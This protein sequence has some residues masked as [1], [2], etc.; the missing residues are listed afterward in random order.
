M[1]ILG[2]VGV[3]ALSVACAV[4]GVR[5]L[6]VAARTRELPELSMGIAFVASGALGFPLLVSSQIVGMKTPGTLSHLLSAFGTL[7]TYAG[8][9]GLAVGTWRIYRARASS[10]ATRRRAAFAR[11]RSGSAS[12]SASRRSDGARS[13]ASSST[14]RCGSAC[15]WASSRRRSP[16]A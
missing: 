5:L 9:I 2:V 14:G 1:E 15:A 13:R 4:V 11:S 6:R 10:F 12:A 7:F 3:L 16:T 8:Y